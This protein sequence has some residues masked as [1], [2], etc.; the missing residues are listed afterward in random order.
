MEKKQLDNICTEITEAVYPFLMKNKYPFFDIEPEGSYAK[1]T[2]LDEASDID[3]FIRL[4]LSMEETKFKELV[5]KLS[6]YLV[7]QGY[8]VRMKYASHPYLT[9]LVRGVE[10]DIVPAYKIDDI[11]QMKSAVDRTPLHTKVI[12][13]NLK[14]KDKKEVK[15][16]KRFLKKH[17]LYGASQFVNGF[18]GY[19]CELL[20]A[21]YG[22]F[23]EVLKH[24]IK[25]YRSTVLNCPI[26]FA[27]P[28]D[29]KRNVAAALS[30]E[31][32]HRFLFFARNG[33][34][35]KRDS[36][37]LLG[38]GAGFLVEDLVGNEEIAFSKFAKKG[39]KLSRK[40]ELE[41]FKLIRNPSFKIGNKGVSCFIVE[42]PKLPLSK[43]IFG[44]KMEM[45]EECEK[46]TKKHKQ[47]YPFKGRLCV[48]KIPKKRNFLDIF[49]ELKSFGE[50]LK[51]FEEEERTLFVQ[52]VDEDL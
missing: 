40:I 36:Y 9:V 43:Q 50:A 27:D 25:D 28:V 3:L 48:D 23:E 7:Q 31:T 20:I 42:N 52:R 14:E 32:Y 5:E 46:F 15:K 2:M 37:F 44:P 33:D 49:P 35:I 19:F 30:F 38:K 45:K 12:N 26:F 21:V 17:N 51:T 16:L 24:E 6:S 10:V 13:E 29:T 18:S 47:V 1:G 11:S 39:R 41:G 34:N 22:S 8:E 4:D